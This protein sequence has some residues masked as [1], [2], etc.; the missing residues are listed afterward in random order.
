MKKKIE[1]PTEITANIVSGK[2]KPTILI[3]LRNKI[4][5]FNELK[6][7]IPQISARILSIQLKELG[8]DDLISKKIY[9]EVPTRVEYQ[10]TKL[11]ELI[12]PILD[13]MLEWG[14][15]YVNYKLNNVIEPDLSKIDLEKLRVD[16][17]NDFNE[18]TRSKINPK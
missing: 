9:A 3:E 14:T 10:L 13:Q 17:A 6:K 1:C 5:R 7:T 16:W 12:Q 11:G 4:L 18:K 2:W 8:E 15:I